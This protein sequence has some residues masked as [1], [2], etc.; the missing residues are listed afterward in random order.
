MATRETSIVTLFFL[1]ETLED[2]LEPLEP[3]ST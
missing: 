1:L 2:T 3:Q